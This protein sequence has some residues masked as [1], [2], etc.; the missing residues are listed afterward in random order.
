MSFAKITELHDEA[1][2]VYQTDVQNAYTK[3]KQDIKVDMIHSLDD[4]HMQSHILF[5]LSAVQ[6][7]AV[8]RF[9]R[10]F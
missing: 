8:S 4:V 1:S 6:I 10:S 3:G 5:G 2:R 7:Q 9:I